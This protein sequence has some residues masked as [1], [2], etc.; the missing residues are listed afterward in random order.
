M[1]AHEKLDVYRCSIEVL[2]LS[3]RIGEAVP[4][5]WSTGNAILL[6]QPKRAA[7]SIPLNIVEGAG[8]QGIEDMQMSCGDNSFTFTFT[9]TECDG[10]LRVPKYFKLCLRGPLAAIIGGTLAVS[11]NGANV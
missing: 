2:A 8:K 5:Y 4:L 6:E 9:S 1:L 11:P 7:L 3:A 10:Q